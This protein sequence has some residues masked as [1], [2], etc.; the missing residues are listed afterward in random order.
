M[1]VSN[2][3][4]KFADNTTV[5]GLI[6]NN[7][8]TAYR[9]EVRA[10]GVWCQENN[11]SQDINETKGDDHGFRKQQREH[12]PIHIDGTVVEKMHNREHPVGLHHRLVRQLLRPQPHGSLDG[13]AVCTTHHR[14]Q[15][16]CPP[17][18]LQHPISLPVHP[19]IIQ[20]ARCIKAG[21]EILK[22]SFNLKAIR[23]LNSH[24]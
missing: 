17:G 11:L 9:E 14:G 20:K 1:H 7:D 5:V 2:T 6:T 12:P 15:T 13:S 16:T 4:I 21:T 19:I 8:E 10:L 3:I 23:L 24:H 22:N 18:Y